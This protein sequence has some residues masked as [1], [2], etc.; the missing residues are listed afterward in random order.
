MPS[1]LSIINDPT[2]WHYIQYPAD[3]LALV[4]I[5]L[6]QVVTSVQ[7]N[8]QQCVATILKIEF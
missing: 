3:L 4:G 1:D 7:C 2:I 5:H 8:A 6:P